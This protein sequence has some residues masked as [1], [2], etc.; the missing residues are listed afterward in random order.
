M[1]SNEAPS[2]APAA[3]APSAKMSTVPDA[4]PDVDK[5]NIKSSNNRNS[6]NNNAQSPSRPSNPR[7][8]PSSGSPALKGAGAGAG[9]TKPS[10]PSGH[11]NENANQDSSKTQSHQRAADSDKPSDTSSA[12]KE[13]KSAGSEHGPAQESQRN[14][15]EPT[16]SSSYNH[17]PNSS[18]PSRGGRGRGSRGGG[19]SFTQGGSDRPSESTNDHSSK[20]L[21]SASRFAASSG[22]GGRGRGGYTSGYSS[23]GRG[24]SNGSF[25]GRGDVRLSEGEDSIR[26]RKF[27]RRPPSSSHRSAHPD[28]T[29]SMTT[30]LEPSSSSYVTSGDASNIVGNSN[31]EKSAK[32]STSTQAVPSEQRSSGTT[33]VSEFKRAQQMVTRSPRSPR[34]PRRGFERGADARNGLSEH[35]TPET[36]SVSAATPRTTTES[37]D[38]PK[39]ASAP[40]DATSTSEQSAGKQKPDLTVTPSSAT[41]VEGASTDS[42][43]QS[44]P[45][46]PPKKR[47]QT[48]K[49]RKNDDEVSSTVSAG[50][51]KDN[52]DL[53]TAAPT[54]AGQRGN[55]AQPNA[56]SLRAHSKE[57]S[58]ADTNAKKESTDGTWVPKSKTTRPQPRENS[59]ISPGY[60]GKNP[61]P[62]Y[63]RPH[64]QDSRRASEVTQGAVS[65]DAV[66]TATTDMATSTQRS[67]KKAPK[68]DTPILLQ[69]GWGEPHEAL[70]ASTVESGGWGETVNPALRWGEEVPWDSHVGNV[71]PPDSDWA[72]ESPADTSQRHNRQTPREGRESLN[73]RRD[74]LGSGDQTLS[75]PSRERNDYGAGR[76][77]PGPSRGSAV[78]GDARFSRATQPSG[79]THQQRRIGRY[80]EERTNGDASVSEERPTADSVPPKD[81]RSSLDK[82]NERLALQRGPHPKERRPSRSD[83]QNQQSGDA[84]TLEA[85]GKERADDEVTTNNTTRSGPGAPQAVP[86][87]ANEP[88]TGSVSQRHSQSK[89]GFSQKSSDIRLD[90]RYNPNSDRE[91]TGFSSSRPSYSR[92]GSSFTSYQQRSQSSSSIV[93]QDAN[94]QRGS[95]PGRS[96]LGNASEPKLRTPQRPP[97]FSTSLKCQ[98]SWEEMGLKPCVLE[99]IQ[100]AGLE[101]P[102]NIQKLM[103]KPFTEGRDVLA[104]SQSQRDRTNTLGMAL[105]QKLS[106]SAESDKRCKAIVICSDGTDPARVFKDLSLWF[107]SSPDLRCLFLEDASGDILADPEQAKQV[108]VTTLGPLMEVLNKNLMQMSAVETVMISMRSDELV[109]FD[110]FKRFWALLP[111]G[112]QVVLMTGLIQ[113]K[114]QTIKDHNFRS[115]AAVVRADELTLQWSEHYYVD[116]QES[117]AEQ[118]ER[119]RRERKRLGSNAPDWK[120]EQ[121]REEEGGSQNAEDE[122][123]TYDRRWE[124]LINLLTKNPD[125][126]HIVIITQSQSMT[127]ALTDQLKEQNFP[128]LS[129]WSMADKTAVV[130]QFNEPERCILVLESALME[131]LDLDHYSLLVNY[132]MPKRALHY[133]SSF[134]PFGRSGLRT[135][136]INFCVTQDRIQR[137]LLEE[138]ESMYDIRIQEMKLE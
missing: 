69:S 72:K 100:R 92:S 35:A 102:S 89:E 115:D 19:S 17:H 103:M 28:S 137:L 22:G 37:Q 56:S 122:K 40:T 91:S 39:T 48:R 112:A 20:P 118:K 74:K 60:L 57:P 2:P 4:K 129:I 45:A 36:T 73:A 14:S 11:A 83:L 94:Q 111:R 70:V 127:Q 131:N 18:H 62:N 16:P 7:W 97:L 125:I 34:S 119:L 124:I 114:I 33:G 80:Q 24:G 98:M 106:S 109:G 101:R 66:S 61:I 136:M 71:P 5:Q 13:K 75:R 53:T 46:T 105:L 93:S 87:A 130:K 63:Q 6:N 81:A 104:Q 108:V 121:E 30:K 38:L 44:A 41:I 29:D 134:G 54:A 90:P 31:I 67:K 123:D 42:P 86:A 3:P 25:S 65:G 23:R 84:T 15:S 128:V 135:M 110:A 26:G 43:S 99:S 21:D 85:V 126:S 88:A 133:I 132:E 138:I 107:E 79:E 68:D 95:I 58:G 64:T 55:Q 47:K 10:G 27:D 78:T 59:G 32:D 113:P 116:L 12:G 120:R 9:T 49:N 1:D 96:K 50:S 117:S 77:G 76:D 8:N 82:R 51:G 52:A